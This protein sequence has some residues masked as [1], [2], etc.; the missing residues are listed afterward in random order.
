[1]C[2]DDKFD[3]VEYIVQMDFLHLVSIRGSYVFTEEVCQEMTHK[4]QW[5]KGF[6]ILK[7]TL[8]LAIAA[9]IIDEC[10]QEI[11]DEIL[12]QVINGGNCNDFAHTSGKKDENPKIQIKQILQIRGKKE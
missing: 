7:K 1:M 8:N 4:Q 6:G 3:T 5:G 2:S 11:E 10:M 12:E 9:G